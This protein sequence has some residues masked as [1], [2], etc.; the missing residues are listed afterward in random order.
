MTKILSKDPPPSIHIGLLLGRDAADRNHAKREEKEN[1]KV[2]ANY[3]F[4][5][6]VTTVVRRQR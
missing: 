1:S 5:K 3:I 4:S 2:T 6:P